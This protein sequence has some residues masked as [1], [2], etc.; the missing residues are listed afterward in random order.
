MKVLVVAESDAYLKWA[1]WLLERAPDGWERELV[2]LR[3]PIAP[4]PV[5]AEAALEATAYDGAT[6]PVVGIAGLRRRLRQVDAVVLACT[7]PSIA[8]I[9]LLALP[10]RR[11]VRPVVVAGLPG[12]GL[13]VAERAIRSRRDV[14]VFVAHSRREVEAY[15]SG[16]AAA[17]SPTVVALAGLPFLDVEPASRAVDGDDRVVFAAQ[18]SV[19]ADRGHRIDLLRRLAALGRPAPI[20]KLRASGGE[21]TTHHEP[22][23][24][25]SLWAELVGAGG[26]EPDAVEFVHGSLAAVLERARC[27]VTVSSTAVLEAM[28]RNVPVLIVDDLGVDDHLLNAVFA[29]S[30]VFGPL[31]TA[32]IGRAGRPNARWLDHNYFHPRAEDDW[33]E[34]IE[35]A[36]RRG[37]PRRVARRPRF[38]AGAVRRAGRLVSH[39]PSSRDGLTDNLRVS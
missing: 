26:V 8:A 33:I 19:P 38:V 24:Y 3:S 18:P 14:D 9:S 39:R 34:R 25:P 28:A 16:F 13:P 27:L 20:V 30:D 31:D 15:R 7:G 12:V 35:E 6:V 23:P 32:G 29:G 36:V 17:H 11:T 2:V 37:P 21:A 22:W 1:A 4:S 10:R 5:Q